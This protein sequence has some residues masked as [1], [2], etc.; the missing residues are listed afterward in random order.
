MRPWA[1]RLLALPLNGALS[2]DRLLNRPG[3]QTGV[4][5]ASVTF[6]VTA[7]GRL[8]RAPEPPPT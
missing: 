3:A 5:P 1:V 4:P 6:Y 7:D 2:P 8:R